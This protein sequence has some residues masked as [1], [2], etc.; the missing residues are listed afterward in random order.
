MN[1]QAEAGAAGTKDWIALAGRILIAALFVQAGYAKITGFAG[2][3]AWIASAALPMPAV[4]T[5]VAIAVELGGGLLLIAGYRTRLVALVLAVF[6]L[7]ASVMFHHYWTLPADRQMVDY[8][9]FWK[10]LS[11]VG[12][13]ATVY[14][15]GPGRLSVDKG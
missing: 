6:T 8:L 1:M 15:F 11:I 14:A 3:A 12:G 2:T 10:N 5:A 4:A 13:L 7:V 9:M